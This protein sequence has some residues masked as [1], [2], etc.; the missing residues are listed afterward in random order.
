[1]G[2]VSFLTPLH[3]RSDCAV[4]ALCVLP[5]RTSCVCL[6]TGPTEGCQP[7]TEYVA[8]S[9][10]CNR[11]LWNSTAG[12]LVVSLS[13]GRLTLLEPDQTG[14]LSIKNA[15]AAHTHEPWCVA[16]NY[17]DTNLIYSGTCV[18][19]LIRIDNHDLIPPGGD[20]L[21]LK[22]WDIRQGFDQPIITNKRCAASNECLQP[23]PSACLGSTLV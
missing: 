8:S 16:W 6:S 7:G 19:D 17:W 14:Q 5:H 15:W 12:S 2:L 10:S 18:L 20:D 22:V 9:A 3:D 4:L 13:D 23:L 11:S 21:R 1:M